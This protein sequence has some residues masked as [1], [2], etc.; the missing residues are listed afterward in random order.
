MSSH[1][2][3][4][5]LFLALF[6]A[7]LVLVQLPYVLHPEPS[8]DDDGFRVW[9]ASRALRRSGIYEASRLPGFPAIELLAAAFGNY[10]AFNLFLSVLWAAGVFGV[11]LC[12]DALGIDGIAAA[13]AW[14]AGST[15]FAS[16]AT[17]MDYPLGNFLLIFGLYALLRG[18][19]A[20]AALL[21]GIAVGARLTN[22]L[23]VLASL[24]LPPAGEPIW[25]W[26]KTEATFAVAAMLAAVAAL[27][28]LP[29]ARYG[30]GFLRGYPPRFSALERL[31]WFLYRGGQLFGFVASGA[32]LALLPRLRL[33]KGKLTGFVLTCSGLYVAFFAFLPVEPAY[34]LPAAAAWAIALPKAL[35][36]RSFALLLGALVLAGFVDI[37]PIDPYRGPK[38]CPT[39]MPGGYLNELRR[40]SD[41]TAMRNT[42]QSFRAPAPFL[43]IVG[44]EPPFMQWSEGFVR[45]W[46][47]PSGMTVWRRGEGEYFVA[48]PIKS[49]VDRAVKNGFDLYA[50]ENI[51]YLLEGYDVTLVSF[52]R[53][54]L[55]PRSRGD[56]KKF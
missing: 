35:P 56:G 5:P 16:A 3:R 42:I 48:F 40:R 47:D 8:S 22:G 53:G 17:C 4:K 41:I 6:S 26:R 11:G 52:P 20:L 38:L 27:Y 50:F 19:R 32:L 29:L 43:F 44:R 54:R 18:R 21:W 10:H 2:R 13:A 24:A 55:W 15:N 33:P 36:R 49:I 7:L 1:R 30:W 31:E 39:L 9:L 46:E 12:A 28:S 25:R 51:A 23:F 37:Y 34:L 14:A 45:A